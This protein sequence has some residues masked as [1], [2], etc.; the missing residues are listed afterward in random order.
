MI[1]G[2][3][4]DWISGGT[5]QDGVIGDDGRIFTSRN[6]AG[7]IA[8]FSESLYAINFLLATDPDPQHPQIIH[9]NVIS[10]FVYTPGQVQTATLNVNQ[11]LKKTVDITPFNLTP[12]AAGADNPLFDANVSDDIIFGGLDDDFLHGASGDDAI[13]GGEALTDSY[14]QRFV[15]GVV[16]GLVRTDFSRPW[17]PGDILK[18]GSDS[19]P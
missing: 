8:N 6:T 17:N 15:N 2:W 4:N 11:A 9:G 3:G 14:T 18:F 7:N 12:T 16:V 19:D 5:G 10:E 1:G 13:G